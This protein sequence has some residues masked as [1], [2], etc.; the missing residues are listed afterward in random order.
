[1]EKFTPKSIISR[2]LIF[3]VICKKFPLSDKYI[4]TKH[5]SKK[6]ECFSHIKLF[7]C[8]DFIS[9]LSQFFIKNITSKYNNVY[10][11]T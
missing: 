5:T 4:K 10:L 11:S 3:L 2:V 6:K 7:G 9:H 1:M 8:Y